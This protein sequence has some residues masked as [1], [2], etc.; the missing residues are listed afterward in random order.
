MSYFNSVHENSLAC[1]QPSTSSWFKTSS[2]L[3][4]ELKIGSVVVKKCGTLW[5]GKKIGYQYSEWYQWLWSSLGCPEIIQDNPASRWYN[6]CTVMLM[7]INEA[8]NWW[9]QCYLA[10]LGIH[11]LVVSSDDGAVDEQAP[12]HHDGF[13]HFSQCHLYTNTKKQTNILSARI[14]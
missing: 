14:L 5:V 9:E 10:V 12:H 8:M 3:V 7:L 1:R 6:V 13:K 2:I 11:V 4:L